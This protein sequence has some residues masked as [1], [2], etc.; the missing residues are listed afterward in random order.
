MHRATLPTVSRGMRHEY[1]LRHALSRG[2]TTTHSTHTLEYATQRRVRQ[3]SQHVGSSSGL[4]GLPV[5]L[6]LPG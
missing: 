1:K 3:G 5:T 4:C 6:A 2:H